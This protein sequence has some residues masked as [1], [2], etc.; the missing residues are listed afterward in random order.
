M[1][2]DTLTIEEVAATIKNPIT[3][4]ALCNRTVR[5]YIESGLL[6]EAERGVNPKTRRVTWLI[7]KKALSKLNKRLEQRDEAMRRQYADRLKKNKEIGRKRDEENPERKEARIS[8][9]REKR[10]VKS[11]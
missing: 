2:K 7:P 4:K 3:G 10:T 9:M 5:N 8:A 6:A 1:A 11:K